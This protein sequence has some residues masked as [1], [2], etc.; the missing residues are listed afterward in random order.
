[1][2]VL[3]VSLTKTKV[4]N[5]SSTSCLVLWRKYCL[6]F[7]LA[8]LPGK[9]RFGHSPQSMVLLLLLLLLLAAQGLLKF[10]RLSQAC[11]VASSSQCGNPHWE[12]VSG[13][14]SRGFD[15]RVIRS[16]TEV[17]VFVFV[18]FQSGLA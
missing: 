7:F 15:S 11:P 14:A 9:R 17:F 16:K 10:Q 6:L 1:M 12:S 2:I 5:F 4:M 3:C 8:G 13:G 18:L